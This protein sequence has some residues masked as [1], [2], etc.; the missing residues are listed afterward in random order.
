MRTLHARS[1][2][3]NSVW[4]LTGSQEREVKTGEMWSVLLIKTLTSTEDFLK[5][6][7]NI[8]IKMIQTFILALTIRLT[9]QSVCDPQDENTVTGDYLSSSYNR[10]KQTKNR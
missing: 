3:L 8:F 7:K 1:K 4:N 6:L 2:I 10:N 5:N 9:R